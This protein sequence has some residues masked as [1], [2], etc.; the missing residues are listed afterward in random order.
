MP[1][2]RVSKNFSGGLVLPVISN[3]SIAPNSI[4]VLNEEDFNHYTVKMAIKMGYL[5]VEDEKNQSKTYVIKIHKKEETEKIQDKETN[6]NF[7]IDVDELNKKTNMVSWDAQ[8]KELVDK[9]KSMKLVMEQN[10]IKE[11]KGEE[12]KKE[13]KSQKIKIKSSKSTK[14]TSKPVKKGKSISPVGEV[15]EEIKSA[16]VDESILLDGKNLPPAKPGDIVLEPT[17]DIRFVDQQQESERI[18]QLDSLRNKQ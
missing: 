8:Q 14:K 12:V 16:Q 6:P 9:E 17:E 1:K 11:A 2:V 10:N 15:K 3:R 4:H 5:V 7:I 13:E 18:S